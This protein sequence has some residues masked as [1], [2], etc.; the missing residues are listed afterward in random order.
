MKKKNLKAASI[1]YPINMYM[2]CEQDTVGLLSCIRL[3]WL[4][5]AA[6]GPFKISRKIIG[7]GKDGKKEQR[8]GE[9]V[10]EVKGKG[11]RERETSPLT[12][13]RQPVTF[14]FCGS[15]CF[16]IISHSI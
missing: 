1:Q 8:H 12:G 13:R 4:K 6:K 7:K 5:R 14:S 11:E 10:Y 16:H 15:S 2:L 3:G 9:S